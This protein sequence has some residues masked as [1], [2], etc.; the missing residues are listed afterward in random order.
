[1][2]KSRAGM[3][4]GGRLT[5]QLGPPSIELPGGSR[6]WSPDDGLNSIKKLDRRSSSSAG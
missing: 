4:I 3:T 5:I 1:V 2:A 6:A